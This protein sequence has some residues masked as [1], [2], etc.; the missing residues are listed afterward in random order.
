MAAK[1]QQSKD[2]IVKKLFEIFPNAFYNGKELRIPVLEDGSELQIKVGLTCAKENVP[3]DIT[4]ISS[5]DATS[6]FPQPI[7]QNP[8]SV[9]S[10]SQEEIENLTIMMQNLNYGE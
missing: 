5:L 2:M 6:D 9:N 8:I 4:S 1:G 10:P 7:K 3:H